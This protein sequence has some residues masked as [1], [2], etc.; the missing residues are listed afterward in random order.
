[1]AA[2]VRCLVGWGLTAVGFGA[3]GWRLPRTPNNQFDLAPFA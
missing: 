2:I 1:M 3:A